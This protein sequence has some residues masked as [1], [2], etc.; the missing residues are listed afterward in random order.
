MT[1]QEL[2]DTATSA[3]RAEFRRRHHLCL[4]LAIAIK[5][6]ILAGLIFYL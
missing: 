1:F 2:Y 6:A 4:K 3:E 5:L